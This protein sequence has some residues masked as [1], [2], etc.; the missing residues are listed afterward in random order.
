MTDYQKKAIFILFGLIIFYVFRIS[1]DV[2]FLRL[3]VEEL[4]AEN[5]EFQRAMLFGFIKANSVQEKKHDDEKE[6]A[7]N[8]IDG[9]TDAGRAESNAESNAETGSL[10]NDLS[11]RKKSR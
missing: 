9:N 7:G 5:N 6:N 11:N 4:R 2:R 1:L 3:E 8:G 10:N